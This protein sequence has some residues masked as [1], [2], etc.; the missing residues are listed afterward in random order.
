MT[1]ARQR[2]MRTA[3]L[4]CALATIAGDAAVAET[5]P[6]IAAQALLAAY[7]ASLDR[8]DNGDIVTRS[9]NRIPIGNGHMALPWPE[10]L[11]RADIVDMFAKPYAAGKRNEPPPLNQDP[12]RAKSAALFDA[13]YGNCTKNDTARYIVAV[14]WLPKKAG[15]T[16]KVTS[17]NGT[18]T[19]LAAVSKELDE[20]PAS[21][22]RF[23]KNPAGGYACRHVAGS[24]RPSAHGWG[25]A[26]DIAAAPAN[27]WLWDGGK[28]HKEG[29]PDIRYRNS[30][31]QEI[32]DIFERHGFIWGGNW[33]HY[34]TMHFEYRP[35]LFPPNPPDRQ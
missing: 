30:V 23:L 13:M 1:S 4:L 25:I 28:V 18:A 6:S 21:F 32:I 7:P 2:S 17:I 35:E 33:Y 20:L 12:G 11:D 5:T 9:G 19:A 31:P 29:S 26:V 27:Y 34:D 24:K 15:G 10:L 8:I 3:A 14:S 16:I 22:D